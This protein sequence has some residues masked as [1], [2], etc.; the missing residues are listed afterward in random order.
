MSLQRINS[1]SG[2]GVDYARLGRTPTLVT[3]TTVSDLG[4]RPP[5]EA[6]NVNEERIVVLVAGRRDQRRLGPF[7]KPKPWHQE[8]DSNKDTLPGNSPYQFSVDLS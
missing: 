5:W 4:E 1:A 8:L 2:S 7:I 6:V 3:T